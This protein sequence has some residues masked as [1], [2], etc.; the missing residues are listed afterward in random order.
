MPTI[1]YTN[2]AVTTLAAG[3]AP[4]DLALTVAA[5]TGARF[6]TLAGA[7]YFYCTL[8]TP[9]GTVEIVRVTARATDTFTIV[10]AQDGTTALTWALGSAVELRI[11][12]AALANMPKLD[13]ANVFTA[14]QSVPAGATGVQVPQAQEVVGKTGAQTMAGPL[15]VTGDLSVGDDLGVTGDLVVA[16]DATVAS[17]NG[18]QLAGM[19]NMVINGGLQICQRGTAYTVPAGTAVPN[20]G[21]TLSGYYSADRMLTYCTGASV[22]HSVVYAIGLGNRM[23]F[24]GAAS[25]TAI[26]VG[27]RIESL[28]THGARGKVCTLSVK[29]SN[30]LL[31]SVSWVASYANTTDAFGTIATPT[32]TTIASGTFTVTSTDTLY[33]AQFTM[34]SGVAGGVEIMFTVGA[35]TSGFWYVGDMQVE[36]GAVATPF[37]W[38]SYETE[39]ALCQRYCYFL[40]GGTNAVTGAAFVGIASAIANYVISTIQFPRPMQ[41]NAIVFTLTGLTGG[42]LDCFRTGTSGSTISSWFPGVL[43]AGGGSVTTVWGA[44]PTRVAGDLLW[45]ALGTTTLLFEA[46]I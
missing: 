24:T 41:R 46:E 30:T 16:G 7:E 29:M 22:T 20:T 43:N 10:R 26:G 4:G 15:T 14:A 13:E 6:P 11:V 39:L 42:T 9:A 25:V 3:I 33:S 38:R 36:V 40:G 5:G 19:R 35:Q 27:Q 34:P 28:Y 44:S 8:A 1:K 17:L 21:I 45:W 23:R 2:N 12:A 18:G 32:K 37:E 31:T